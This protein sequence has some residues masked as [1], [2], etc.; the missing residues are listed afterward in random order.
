M[1]ERQ[2]NLSSLFGQA[3]AQVMSLHW[4]SNCGPQ[5]DWDQ[6]Q[7][8]VLQGC[9]PLQHQQEG[10]EVR[11]RK[12]AL[13][14]WGRGQPARWEETWKGSKR[15]NQ[16]SRV[17]LWPARCTEE[18]L[19]QGCAGVPIFAI[20]KY[21]VKVEGYATCCHC[22]LESP[23]IPQLK[24]YAHDSVPALLNVVL[25]MFHYKF[26]CFATKKSY[27]MDISN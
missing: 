5:D 3:T 4:K 24:S 22:V 26:K 2:V 23:W 11:R 6:D 13:E 16:D 17:R 8:D 14:D 25:Q 7:V 20:K 27:E 9:R 18:L 12:G 1:F 10:R 15:L 21:K 19:G